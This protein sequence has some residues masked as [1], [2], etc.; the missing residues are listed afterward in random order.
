MHAAFDKTMN[1][2]HE[3][4]PSVCSVGRLVAVI[5]S[6]LA[7]SSAAMAFQIAPMGSAFESKLT[8]ETENSLAT[9][10]GR[11][12]VLIKGRVHEEITQIGMGCPIE[13]GTL[14][15][16]LSCSLRDLPFATPYVIYGVRWNDLPPFKLSPDEGNC[17]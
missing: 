12:G 7:L 13:P 11:L 5:A 15:Q 1:H 8:N 10:A 6:A 2:R 3:S 16:D 17:T 9:V 14:A 4:S